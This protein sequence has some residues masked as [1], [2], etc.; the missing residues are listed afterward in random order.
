ME[1]RV[2]MALEDMEVRVDKALEDTED[3]VE[4]ALEV[5]AASLRDGDDAL[6]HDGYMSLSSLLNQDIYA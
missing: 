3:Q 1:V 6:Y 5:L 2:E 4:M